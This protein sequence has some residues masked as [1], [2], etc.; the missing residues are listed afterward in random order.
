MNLNGYPLIPFVNIPTLADL[1]KIPYPVISK[2]DG[3]V[4]WRDYDMP[5][6]Y[7]GDGEYSNGR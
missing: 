2:A 7:V 4:F 5:K 1:T 3:F 6:V